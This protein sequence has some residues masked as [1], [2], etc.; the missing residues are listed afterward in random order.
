MTIR[1]VEDVINGKYP[2]L[3]VD[4]GLVEE[5]IKDWLSRYF[6]SYGSEIT[7]DVNIVKNNPSLINWTYTP[8]YTDE[9]VQILLT[10]GN[11]IEK[12]KKRKNLEYYF[13]I[14]LGEIGVYELD[15]D[16]IPKEAGPDSN[17]HISMDYR[18]NP[19]TNEDSL[20]L[21][22]IRIAFECIMES[23]PIVSIIL[24]ELSKRQ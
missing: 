11:G 23:K 16:K 1:I 2:Y 4:L 14:T 3:T 18:K 12:L 21:E 24:F 22:G 17:P 10:D 8:E 19:E 15:L 13:T 5:H 6:T 7:W 9:V 20:I